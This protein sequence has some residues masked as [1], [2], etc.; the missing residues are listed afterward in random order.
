MRSSLIENVF[1][2]ELTGFPNTEID[3]MPFSGYDPEGEINSTVCAK[4]S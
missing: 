3:G 4:R 1:M 2:E